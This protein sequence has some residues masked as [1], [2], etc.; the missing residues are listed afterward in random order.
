M[1]ELGVGLDDSLATGW[2]QPGMHRLPPGESHRR[3]VSH[4]KGKTLLSP[5]KERRASLER[6]VEE[7]SREEHRGKPVAMDT[8]KSLKSS[9]VMEAENPRTTRRRLPLVKFATS[10]NLGVNAGQRGGGI[11]T[12]RLSSDR[13]ANRIDTDRLAQ[14]AV[15]TLNA[16]KNSLEESKAP[17]GLRWV[18]SASQN[19]LSVLDSGMFQVETDSDELPKSENGSGRHPNTTLS[20]T[21]LSQESAESFEMDMGVPRMGGAITD[22]TSLNTVVSVD[23]PVGTQLESP[24]STQLEYEDEEKKQEEME[25]LS[26]LMNKSRKIGVRFGRARGLSF[27]LPERRNSQ[28]EDNAGEIV[29]DESALEGYTEEAADDQDVEEIEDVSG[30]VTRAAQAG[31]ALLEA[32][33]QSKADVQSSISRKLAEKR[34][35][36]TEKKRAFDLSQALMGPAA[37]KVD[38][39]SFAGPRVRRQVRRH[40]SK[41]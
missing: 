15:Q 35:I 40:S 23:S 14:E 9:A 21:T 12:A 28:I 41:V 3:R 39:A 8:M 31:Q 34:A 10:G 33:R 25:K 19:D 1:H 20:H 38:M 18:K 36:A 32:Q 6:G 26:T 7:A 11:S 22:W 5:P 16:R 4:E 37:P 2:Y 29:E 30:E 27:R 13:N 24:I 17:V